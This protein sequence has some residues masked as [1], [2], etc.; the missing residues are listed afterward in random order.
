M[1]IIDPFDAYETTR[2]NMTTTKLQ[3]WRMLKSLADGK[4]FIGS[5]GVIRHRGRCMACPVA[6]VANE[7]IGTSISGNFDEAAR[8]LGLDLDYA[9]LIAHAADDRPSSRLPIGA[10]AIRVKEVRALLLRTL[11][12]S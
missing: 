5:L 10:S 8:R 3:F 12:L 4:W 9:T 2:R 1:C 6:A 7:F 11:G